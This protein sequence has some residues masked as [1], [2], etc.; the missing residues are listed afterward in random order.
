MIVFAR[1][2]SWLF[3]R[4]FSGHRF[5]ESREHQFAHALARRHAPGGS[6]DSSCA[7][8][9]SLSLVPTDRVR[10]TLV[11]LE[12]CGVE[13][14]EEEPGAGTGEAIRQPSKPNFDSTEVRNEFS[15]GYPPVTAPFLRSIRAGVTCHPFSSRHRR[16]L[17]ACVDAGR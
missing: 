3:V 8:S 1:I 7:Y 6:K 11:W 14:F 15:A 4:R 2:P 12:P 5:P 9:S 16:L 10:R 17:R 13:P